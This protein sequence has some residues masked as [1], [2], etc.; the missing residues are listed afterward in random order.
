MSIAAQSQG[1]VIRIAFNDPS[2]PQV[3]E[4]GFQRL[5]VERSIDMGISWEEITKPSERPALEVNKVDYVYI[6]RKGDP[7]Y[8]YR[9]RYVSED[10]KIQG[11][12]SDSID[13]SGVLLLS[14]LTVAQLKQRYL[15]GVN[16]TDDNGNQLPDE[17][18]TFYILSA[19]RW[20]EHQLDIKLLPTS[21]IDE[22]HD[23]Y[24]GDYPE[25]CIIQLD[26]YPVISVEEFVVQYPSGQTVVSYPPEWLRVDPDHGILRVVPTAGTLSNVMLAQGGAFL[27][28]VFSG[29]SHLPDLFK[30]SYTAGFQRVPEN[31]LDLIGMFASMGP[32]NI[33]GDLIAGA[34]I[35]SLSMSIDGLSQSIGTTSSAT[36]AGYGARI[37]QY[38]KQIKEQIPILRRYYKGLRM[39]VA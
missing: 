13:G 3:I 6:D 11:D 33:F 26:N 35:A 21:I 38:G 7:S 36:N 14:L 25:F 24:R 31:I 18:F 10:G 28:A 5:R 4:M 32:F 22:P 16:L 23:Y 17:V 30:V 34:G 15:F 2:I 8:K 1:N 39:T 37:I 20:M 27:P 29:L 9:T 12:P 19:V